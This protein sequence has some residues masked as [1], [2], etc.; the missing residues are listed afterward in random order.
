METFWVYG[1]LDNNPL[2]SCRNA[3]TAETHRP[4]PNVLLG[5]FYFTMGTMVQLAY[6]ISLTVIGRKEHLRFAAYKMM[7]TLGCTDMME[8]TIN[9]QFTGYF[10]AVGTAFCDLPR[11]I[12]C[13]G[14]FAHSFYNVSCFLS[15]FLIFN[16]L[17]DV[18]GSGMRDFFFKG[19]RTL[20]FIAIPFLIGSR[21]YFFEH[22]VIF[23][24]DYGTWIFHPMIPG[25]INHEYLVRTQNACNIIV[26]SSLSI[27]CI[28]IYILQWRKE[29]IYRLKMVSYKKKVLQQAI[30]VCVF[31]YT[32]ALI[33][34]ILG[35]IPQG[36]FMMT[37]MH[38]GHISW[39]LM[40]STPALVYLSFNEMIRT[41]VFK[42][43]GL[44]SRT[45][46]VYNTGTGERTIYTICLI[47]IGRKD[48]LQYAAYKMMF[49]LV[50]YNA[51]GYLSLFLLIN[52]LLDV[53]DSSLKSFFYKGKRT[54]IFILIAL[55]IGTYFLIF[56]PPGLFNADFGS[57]VFNPMIP[58]NMNQKVLQ[59]AILVWCLSIS[60]A[61]IWTT[62]SIFNNSTYLMLMM[63]VGHFCWFMMH[64]TPALI[65][66]FFNETIRLEVLKFLGFHSFKTRVNNL[67]L[68]NG[69]HKG[70]VPLGILWITLG[71]VAQVGYIVSLSVIGQKEYLK[72][73]AFKLMFALGIV[74]LLNLFFCADLSGYFVAVGA[75]FC[76]FPV[77][78]Y[79]VGGVTTFLFNTSCLLS[80]L[81]MF[82][83]LLDIAGSPVKGFLFKGNRTFF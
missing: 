27:C 64:S 14:A 65:Y 44:A 20:I 21:F 42:I 39:I 79:C 52:R 71:A 16:R 55:L 60:V 73:C 15:V 11:L 33:W 3:S 36:P 4:K 19:K 50:F 63:H 23:N 25:N 13:L 75:T 9:S 5:M 81:L 43:V 46:K 72:F 22:P 34:C 74:D 26:T 30:L 35:F 76:D 78:I 62:L 69:V 1:G 66:L 8:M 6:L 82:N 31:T 77:L 80:A 57:W 45:P 47:V 58:G 29:K 17:L 38:I 49:A 48:L 18:A 70:N 83:R 61:T 41:R 28:L 7:F 2:Y 24:A 37:L 67:G 51:S 12:F 53:A 54:L 68:S 32:T 40:H 56:E 59:Q 10:T